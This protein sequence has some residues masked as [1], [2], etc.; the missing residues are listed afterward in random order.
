MALDFIN[1]VN[2][3]PI[4]SRDDLAGPQDVYEWAA[5]AGLL[6]KVEHVAGL[7]DELSQFRALVVLREQLYGV[8]GPIAH[9]EPPEPRALA[10]LVR[11]A[12]RALRNARWN[13]TAAGLVPQW[14][15][16]SLESIGDRVADAA[17]L[18]LRQPAISRVGFCAGCGW[19]FLD[20]S[21]AHA[22][23]WCSMNACGVRDKM[24][25]YHRRQA[26]TTG[27]A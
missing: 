19:L 16:N 11:R 9:G 7:A 4:F 22:R 14:Q 12:T 27:A 6:R 24:R 20:T 13:R 1:T 15:Q 21:R 8:F 17:V 3:R 2:G 25:R 26:N 18:L 10:F 5:A 23:R